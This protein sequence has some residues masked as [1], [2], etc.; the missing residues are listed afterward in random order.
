MVN[1]IKITA[2]RMG[3]ISKV[4]L[5]RYFSIKMPPFGFFRIGGSGGTGYSPAAVVI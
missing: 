2:S 3:M 5:I 4:R 1:T